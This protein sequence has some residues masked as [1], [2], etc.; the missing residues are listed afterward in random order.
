MFKKYLYCII[1]TALLSV[2]STFF[3]Q[4]LRYNRLVVKNRDTTIEFENLLRTEATRN[5]QL[6]SLNRGLIQESEYQLRKTVEAEAIIVSISTGLS[7]DVDTVDGI[8]EAIRAIKKAIIRYE[9]D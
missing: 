9:D 5:Q 2:G 6:E 3:I 4:Q 7:G 8:I 1:I